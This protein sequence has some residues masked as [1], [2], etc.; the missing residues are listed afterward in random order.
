MLGVD[1]TEAAVLGE[2]E[3]LP[4]VALVLGCYVIPP[5]A[6]LAGKGDGWSL[7]RRHCLFFRFVLLGLER[8]L[9]PGGGPE[10][11]AYFKILV[12]RPAPTVRP[13]SRMAKRR[14][15]S[16]AMGAISSTV[17]SV[18]SPGITIWVPS[19]KVMAPVTSVVRK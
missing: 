7:V 13:P 17:I 16:M 6:L 15:S 19:A 18:L 3:T 14:P 5:L 1:A 9:L 2:L 12:T 8:D 11:F 10:P 4:G